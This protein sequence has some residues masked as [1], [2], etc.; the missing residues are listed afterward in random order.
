MWLK[1]SSRTP[2]RLMRTEEEPML[3]AFTACRRPLWWRRASAHSGNC[4]EAELILPQ[5]V[6]LI[7]TA[8]EVA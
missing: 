1:A 6:L 2:I 7:Y 3:P 8:K 5:R 4:F